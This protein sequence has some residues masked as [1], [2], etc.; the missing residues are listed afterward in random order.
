MEATDGAAPGSRRRKQQK[1]KGKEEKKSREGED[2]GRRA[3]VIGR[4][5][6]ARAPHKPKFNWQKKKNPF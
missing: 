4:R 6:G 1:W 3:R 5:K 2:K